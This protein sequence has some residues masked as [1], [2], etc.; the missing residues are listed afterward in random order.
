VNASAL[1]ERT[2]GFYDDAPVVPV[3]VAARPDADRR[4]AVAV[5]VGLAGALAL[6]HGT[7]LWLDEA[8]SVAI[9][10][11]PVGDLLTA[12]RHD[13]APPLYYLL[14]HGWTRLFGTG[15]TAVRAMSALFAAATVPTAMAAARRT[16]GRATSL[17]AGLV[18]ATLPFLYRYGTEARMYSLVLLLVA[19]GWWLAAT[20]RLI[21]LAVVSGLLLLTHYWGFFLLAPAVVLAAWR[22]GWALAAALAAGGLLFVPWLPA[23][24]YQAAHTGAPWA[25][26]ARIDGFDAALSGFS[27]GAG[28]VGVLGLLYF[29]LAVLA[30]RTSGA[31]RR[32][33][34]ATAVPLALGF[35]VSAVSGAAFAERYAAIVVVPFA[36]L[37]GIGLAHVGTERSTRIVVALVVGGGLLQGAWVVHRQRTQAPELAASIKAVAHPGDRV[38]FCPDQLGPA[39]MRLLPAGIVTSA[40]PA[41]DRGDIVDWVDYADRN[42]AASGAAFARHM[43]AETE[44]AVLVVA[45]PGYRTFGRSCTVLVEELRRLR[46]G[47]QRLVRLDRSSYEHASLWRF[48]AGARTS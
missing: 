42:K 23:F 11:L 25:R 30:V 31:A 12:L 41:G 26:P 43:D 44:G 17:A 39:V 20:R 28:R 45:S 47:D 5:V 40:Y 46:P 48:R 22:R 18:L 9:A 2:A 14:L 16:F 13:G 34:W 10:R 3:R 35:A 29:A 36:V 24:A 15:D 1:D 32:L 33:A 7:G 37:V 19:A 6:A 27:G 8:Q 21:P 38:V 4:L